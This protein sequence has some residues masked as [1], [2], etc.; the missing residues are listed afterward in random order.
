MVAHSRC[1]VLILTVERV[2]VKMIFT[3]IAHDLYHLK[4]SKPRMTSYSPRSYSDDLVQ[5][6]LATRLESMALD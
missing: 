5:N 1:Y 6:P 4:L 2:K 3:A